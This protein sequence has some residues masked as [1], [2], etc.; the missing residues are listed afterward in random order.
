[1]LKTYRQILATPGVTR[2]VAGVIIGGSSIGLAPL[3]F[4]LY[5]H[6]RSGSFTVAGAV[7]AVFGVGRALATPLQGR[8]LDRLGARAVVLPCAALYAVAMIGMLAAGALARPAI[9][10][11][12]AAV[13]AGAAFPP[14]PALLRAAWPRLV[15]DGDEQRLRA[16]Y[17]LDAIVGEVLFFGGITLAALLA[18]VAS[19]AAII[20]AMLVTAVVGCVLAATALE[21]PS[22]GGTTASRGGSTARRA[23]PLALPAVRLA[24]AVWVPVGFVLAT[25]EVVAPAFAMKEGAAWAGGVLLALTGVG[26]VLGALWYGSLRRSASAWRVSSVASVALAGALAV[27]ALPVGF[28]LM[29]GAAVL[30]GVPHGPFATA[31]NQFVVD[32]CPPGM[33]TEAFTWATTAIMIG[34][35]LGGAMAGALVDAGGWRLASAAGAAGALVVSGAVWARLARVV[36]V[37]PRAA[38]R[39]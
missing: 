5:V 14:L 22:P 3:G 2:L 10:L 12:A 15:G 8:L 30:L 28:A 4:M 26:N 16:A 9:P 17:V 18:A 13:A 21:A 11:L 20:V 6:D 36:P 37:V 25:F 1:M 19:S 34:G 31:N 39:M 35:S 27:T 29:A 24:L 33:T 23:G 32:E 7:L 38:E